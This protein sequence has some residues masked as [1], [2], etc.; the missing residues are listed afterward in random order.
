MK[1]SQLLHTLPKTQ[2]LIIRQYSEKQPQQIIVKGIRKDVPKDSEL[3][4]CRVREIVSQ[5]A[6]IIIGIDIS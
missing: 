6:H 1:L 2:P 4:M 3:N 5:Q